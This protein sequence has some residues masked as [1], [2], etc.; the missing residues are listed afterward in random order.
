MRILTAKRPPPPWQVRR[1]EQR[2]ILAALLGQLSAACAGGSRG[3]TPRHLEPCTSSPVATDSWPVLS[4]RHAPF[5]FR[6][7]PNS[8]R[9]PGDTAEIWRTRA[10]TVSYAVTARS[11][12]WLDSAQGAGM[13]G[14]IC[15]DTIAGR[16]VRIQYHFGRQA[17]G[18]GHYLLAFWD[19][20]PEQELELVVFSRS[21]GGRDTVFAIAHSVQFADR[22]R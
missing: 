9:L 2:V 14:S 7:P 6:L 17:F 18:E 11:T 19:L 5:T 16:R 13:A 22:D 1:L 4:A 8:E 12:R 20:G 3:D 21:P 15:E 10:G